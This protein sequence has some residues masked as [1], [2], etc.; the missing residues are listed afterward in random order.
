[1]KNKKSKELIR[2][3]KFTIISISAG[4]I[5]VGTF[6]LFNDIFK[7]NYWLAYLLSLLL[8][9]LWNFTI[10]RNYTFKSSN[11]ITKSMLLVLAFYAIFT[12]VSTV[13]GDFVTKQGVHDYIV[14]VVTMV[15]NFILEFLYTRYFV[16]KNSCDT[17][18]DISN[19]NKKP[20]TYRIIRG[21][22]NFFFH[23]R[24]FLKKSNLPKEPCIIVT[25]HSQMYGPICCELYL[26][27]PKTIWCISQMLDKK[28]VRDYAYNDFWSEKPKYIRWYFKMISKLF[29]PLLYHLMYYSNTLPVYKDNRIM[30]TFKESI[31]KLNEGHNII[32]FPESRNPFNEIINDFQENFVDLAK[33]YYRRYNKELYFVPMYNAV[34]LKKMVYGTPIKY[35]P[36]ID[37]EEQ[38]HL[39]C[40]HLKQEITTLAKELPLHKVV[41]YDNLPRRK[42]KNNK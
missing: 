22:I 20:L 24:T 35:D 18:D 13:L 41:P 17:K 16:Y 6:A 2:I 40:N 30:A 25:N 26:D 36:N 28:E 1:M 33:L 11:N 39:I 9:I 3:I 19:P 4:L 42:Y 29:G 12:P 10:N 21:T 23:K 14:L 34:N 38:K 37:L 27:D 32:I 15:S 8:S 31:K 5:Q 7:W